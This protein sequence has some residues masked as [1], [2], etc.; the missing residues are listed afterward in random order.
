MKFID[1]AIIEIEAGDGGNGCVAWRREKYVPRG[2]PSGGD[3]GD[4]GSVYLQAQSGLSTLMD[5]RY[6]KRIK[7]ERGQ[8]GMGKF[9]NGRNGDDAILAVPIGTVV[10]DHDSG[11]ELGELLSAETSMLV[12]QGGK[13][14]RGN[15]H[16]KSSTRQAPDIAEEG[17]EGVKRR[18]RLELKLLADVGLVGFPNA[19][20]STLIASIS[21]AKPKVAEYPFTT[22]VPHLG[23]V[24]LNND[25]SFVLADIP[26]LIEGAHTGQGMGLQFLRHIERTRILLFIIDVMDPER[27]DPLLALENLKKELTAH[28]D[29]LLQRPMLVV[30]SKMDIPEAHE[31]VAAAMQQL[32]QAG[33]ESLSISAATRNGLDQLL[34]VI[35]RHL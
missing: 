31:K 7:A 5:V 35:G 33:V 27:P 16:F 30:F 13:G 1:E 34:E 8:H 23:L 6:R 18:L 12:A 10:Y 11:E 3:G 2:G 24:R 15:V 17:T 22:K 28:H 29:S 14:G 20:K 25:R 21:N 4:G 26:G 19:G 9:K 32:K